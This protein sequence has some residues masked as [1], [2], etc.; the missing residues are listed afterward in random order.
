MIF[1]L[2]GALGKKAVIG[3]IFAKQG[4]Q[5]AGPDKA[6]TGRY[7]FNLALGEDGLDPRN[8]IIWTRNRSQHTIK[9][10]RQPKILIVK[11]YYLMGKK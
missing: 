5:D 3:A 8:H 6:G 11:Q 2:I 4:D 10:L 9:N 1:Y 7:P